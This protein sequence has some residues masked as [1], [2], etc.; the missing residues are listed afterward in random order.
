MAA[1][2]IPGYV[3]VATITY[4]GP[5][6]G[7]AS[8]RP[9]VDNYYRSDN[10]L[11][12][13]LAQKLME[14][15]NQAEPS[16]MYFF[17]RLPPGLVGYENVRPFNEGSRN[18]GQIDRFIY[19]HPEGPF[20]TLD[21]SY[22]HV[23]FLVF[24]GTPR[25]GNACPCHRCDRKRTIGEKGVVR[26]KTPVPC[27]RMQIR[28]VKVLPEELKKLK[29]V[30]LIEVLCSGDQQGQTVQQ[31]RSPLQAQHMQQ[32]QH[33]QQPQHMQQEIPQ[34]LAPPQQVQDMQEPQRMPNVSDAQRARR[35][36]QARYAM[37]AQQLEELQQLQ[38]LRRSLQDQRQPAPPQVVPPH[39]QS[40]YNQTMLPHTH[41][42][43]QHSASRD[44]VAIDPRLTASP[45]SAGLG[46]GEYQEMSPGIMESPA[47]RYGLSYPGP[48]P[49]EPFIKQEDAQGPGGG[50]LFSQQTGQAVGTKRSLDVQQEGETL[51]VG[52]SKRPKLQLSIGDAQASLHA[53]SA[54]SQS[55]GKGKGKERQRPDDLHGDPETQ[56]LPA[57]VK[58]YEPAAGAVQRGK[59]SPWGSFRW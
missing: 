4:T 1:R 6:F 50:I 35:L 52:S 7:N 46:Q 57:F 3:R 2:S 5:A 51:D 55:K 25:E 12:H 38:Q 10:Y 36:Q 32:A 26:T 16:T 47:P 9:S 15:I 27:P 23:K 18:K 53:N 44:E 48:L 30:R 59:V 21:R 29:L 22:D 58:G 42:A 14:E 19:G 45:Q 13:T 31:T 41:V 20:E 8:N 17:D 34:P 28:D 49:R 24:Y 39:L 43:Q 37:Q 33:L 40:F 54:F 56:L 11:R